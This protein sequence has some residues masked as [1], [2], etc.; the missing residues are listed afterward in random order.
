MSRP[1]S[2]REIFDQRGS[3]YDWAMQKYPDARNREFEY[4]IDPLALKDGDL[5]LDLPAGGGYLAN[6]IKP[7]VT[8]IPCDACRTFLAAKQAR[9]NVIANANALPFRDA[10]FDA[11]ASLAG[12]HHE[13]N[14]EVLFTEF[15]RVLKPGGRFCIADVKAGSAVST[16]LDNTVDR[17]NSH[18]HEGNYLQASSLAKIEQAG[19][20]ITEHKVIDFHWQFKD[21]EA[22]LE[23]CQNLF[24]LDLFRRE[25]FLNETDRILGI[26]EQQQGVVLNWQLYYIWGEA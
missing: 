6:Y 2:Y 18:G 14:L 15:H 22:L 9:S 17:F 10:C 7:D 16:F 12:L 8:L 11:L 20:T 13:Q 19:L 1:Q 23:F 24:G 21:I 4:L 3:R 5:M 26:K 25:E